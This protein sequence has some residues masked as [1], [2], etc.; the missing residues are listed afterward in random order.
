MGVSRRTRRPRPRPLLA[1]AL[2]LALVACERSYQVGD[3]VMVEWEGK[4]YPAVNLAQES[5]ANFKVH[6][7]GYEDVWDETVTKSRIKGH[8][9]GDEPR[10]EPPPK[11]RAKALE[12]AK[13]NTYKVGDGVRVEWHGRWYPATIVEIM[14]REQYRVHYQGYGPEWDENVGLARIQA[15]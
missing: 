3:Q 10:P 12:A 1:L 2:A 11:V 14:G 7:E 15:R 9:K 8:R 5:A 13:T 4:E 6:F